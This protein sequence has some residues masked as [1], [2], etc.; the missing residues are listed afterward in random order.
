MRQ[1]C[2]KSCPSLQHPEAGFY[3]ESCLAGETLKI[4]RNHINSLIFIMK[5]E[6]EVDSNECLGYKVKANEIVLCYQDYAYEFH[7]LSD[8]E[9]VVCYF[10]NPGSA[11]NLGNLGGSLRKRKKAFVHEFRSLPFR[12]GF[13]ELL[14]L[15]QM[16]L[17]DDIRCAHMHH[18]MMELV[19]VNL[20]FYYSVDEQ[21]NLLY[22]LFGH[23]VSFISLIENNRSKAKNLK[24]LA[25]MCGYSVNQFNDI[26]RRY[27][28]DKTPREWIQESR[29]VEILN[30]IRCTDI[31]LYDLSEK[32]GFSGPGN[33]CAY[34]KREFGELP[35]HIRKVYKETHGEINPDEL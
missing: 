29:R 5:G 10:A 27:F 1:S 22:N 25:E 7:A 34:C 32:Y 35:S 15:V 14:E 12:G 30:D 4:D 21:L 26:F 33:F 16:Y 20:R 6:C 11:C 13:A 8:M 19:F 17:K 23:S 24:Q 31:R 2:P 3:T 28:P 9:I 18:S